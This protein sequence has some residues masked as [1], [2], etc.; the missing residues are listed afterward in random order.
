MTVEVY[1]IEVGRF[2]LPE[3]HVRARRRTLPGRYLDIL[4]DDSTL[5][6]L[7][8][9]CWLIDHPEAVIL[10]DVGE[11][12]E[13]FDPGGRDLGARLLV[14]LDGFELGP[15]DEVTNRLAE[16]GYDP[17]DVDGVVL[18]HLHFDHAGAVGRIPDADVLVSRREYWIHRTLPLGSPMHRWPDDLDPT[19]LDHRDGQYGPFPA[20]HRL[21][22]D[23]SIRAVPTPGHTP[24][25]Q[26][27]VVEDDDE[28]IVLAG[29]TTF[30]ERQLLEDEVVGIA[31]SARASRRTM[32]R[33]RRLCEHE[34]VVYL[35]THDPGAADRLVDRT[36]TLVGR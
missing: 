7:P 36:P 2:R 17:R 12:V 28:L 4:R 23:G 16:L 8:V 10:V 32:A 3:R 25:H 6:A 18:T 1:P 9:R 31:L 14:D 30:T 5:E 35:P 11:T 26:S 21:T 15:A 27:I 29:D 24:G 19:L 13:V 34:R 22:D 20:S 33:I